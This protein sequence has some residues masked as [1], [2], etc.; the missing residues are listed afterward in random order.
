M[1]A[2][3]FDRNDFECVT[4][5]RAFNAWI[6]RC[7]AARSVCFDTETTGLDVFRSDLV[8]FALG[9]QEGTKVEACYIP[10][11]HQRNLG[12]Q[13][14]IEQT[15]PKIRQL[16]ES[17]KPIIGANLLFDMLV[18]WQERY[19]TDIRNVHDTQLM[20][21]AYTGNL[22]F[23]H[24][25]DALAERIL[26]YTPIKFAELVD[27]DI[28]PNFSHVR[29]DDATAYAAE[30]AAVTLVIAKVLQAKLK[31]AN[32]W[33]VYDKIDRPL[34]PVLRDMK[35]AGIKVDFKK[36]DQLR[37]EWKPIMA[38]LESKAHKQ[39]GK[40]FN[41]R[42]APQ[43]AQLLYSSKEEGGLGITVTNFTDG[44][45]PAADKDTLEQIHG[46]PLVDTLLEF[47]QYATL[48]STFVDGLPRER[49]EL[50]G[51]V[52]A[53]LKITRT[54]T[55][56]FSSAG[57]NLQNIPVRTTEGQELREAFIAEKGHVLISADYSQ[58][59]YRVLTHVSRDPYLLEVYRAGID[60]HA[61]MAADVRGGN[62]QD[63][64]NKA[65]KVR[66]AIRSAFKNV[67]FA[68]IYGAGPPKVARM[69]KISVEEALRLLAAH[70][71]MC[72]GVYDWKD[73]T[74]A[75]AREYGYV[76]N[77]FGG[78]T[79]VQYINSKN[80]EL[81]GHAE[82]LAINAPIQGGAAELIRLAMPSVNRVEGAR[83]LLQVH[84]EL[85][86]ECTRGKAE[87]V[88]ERVKSA[89]ETAADD[90]IEWLV[91]IVAET[92]IGLNWRAAK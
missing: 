59:E 88:A 70:Q 54:K 92:G 22:H 17:G 44:G 45:N 68:T 31:E 21:Y 3:S 37:E 65:D 6:R 78:R 56:R 52:H 9:V 18:M 35:W 43:V 41:L 19:R 63:Y 34:L 8:G 11:G 30:D 25:M 24:G 66:Y 42:S 15:L 64:N 7:E 12:K 85:V 57:P 71:E 62:W 39:A 16:L 33:R 13:L 27:G 47:K 1:T 72:K 79:H 2:L 77:L 76:A 29:L 28:V 60:M 32:L 83:L 55:R 26:S 51:R 86:L 5:E 90:M 80:R 81:K 84:D 23:E 48:V 67:N 61:K 14:G 50:T 20:S 10:V 4:T 75:F 69:S 38:K 36:L 40:K 89:M 91:P 46:V 74:W 58:I 53:D 49:N 87:A 73:E 82:R